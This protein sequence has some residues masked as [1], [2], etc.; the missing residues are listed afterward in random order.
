MSSHDPLAA[1]PRSASHP[2]APASGADGA[3]TVSR[4]AALAGL[5]IAPVVGAAAGLPVAHAESTP[6]KGAAAGQAVIRTSQ[7]R[8]TIRGVGGINF[9]EWIPDLTPAQRETAFGTEEGQL[10]FAV[11]RI[12]VSDRRETW[13]LQLETALRAQ[14]HG[15]I[16]FASPWYPPQEMRETFRREEP[17]G[18][19][20][21]FPAE[22]A[23]R[24]EG[25]RVATGVSG[26][27]GEGYVVPTTDSGAV[28]SWDAVT[29]YRTAPYRLSI[30]YAL[31][32]QPAHLQVR[33]N[34]DVIATEL[35]LPAT[36]SAKDWQEVEVDVPFEA[37]GNA[38][39]LVTVD[40]RPAVDGIRVRR[41]EVQEDAMRLR[42]DAYP[43][44][45]Q[46]LQDFVTFMRENGVDLHA[47]SIQNEPDYAHEWTWWTPAEMVDFLENHAGAIDCRIIAPES[48]QYLKD[49]SD[50]IIRSEAAWANV[51][52]LGAHLYGTQPDA[53]EYPLF[54]E[55]TGDRE[56]W[57]TE[58]YVPNSEPDSNERWPESLV[59]GES[60][61]DAFV[62]AEFQAY[63]WWY[64]RRNYGPI[65]E[66]GSI[67]H[68]GHVMSHFSRFLRAGSQRLVLDGDGTDGVRESAYRAAD[69][70]LVIVAINSSEAPLTR[71]YELAGMRPA[72]VE[73]W[74]TSAEERSAVVDAPV[75]DSTGALRGELPA[76]SITTCVVR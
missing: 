74:R 68:R 15:A 64:I 72:S 5:G 73:A 31:P 75:I 59:V 62:V 58:V 2:P 1:S 22:E 18:A 7:P 10:G 37:G 44:Y 11:L 42:H 12:P 33:V 20:S 40:G 52:I 69:G 24:L 27:R 56:L 9:P 6:Q 67:S 76:Q 70:S 13:G 8:Q 61:H 14:E 45:A 29:A 48:F 3:G 41:I 25:V 36:A 60:I 49:T 28:I 38:V 21:P 4:R 32:S 57:M 71:T 19:G 34:G 43:A 35:E 16:V 54:H 53:F 55:N 23:Q 26:Y 66:D 17:G 50:P 47:I 39:E 30:R 46:H 63:V 51:D 65:S